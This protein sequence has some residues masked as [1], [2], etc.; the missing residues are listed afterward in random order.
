VRC[1]M[2]VVDVEGCGGR[3]GEEL[4]VH[5]ALDIVLTPDTDNEIMSKYKCDCASI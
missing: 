2:I 1:E 4:E 5:A 3:K